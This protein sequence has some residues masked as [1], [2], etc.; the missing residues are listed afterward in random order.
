MPWIY[1]NHVKT[2]PWICQNPVKTEPLIKQKNYYSNQFLHL[3]LYATKN[4][5]ISNK[6]SGFIEAKIT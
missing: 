1:P 5:S 4:L 3:Q 6:K 2:K